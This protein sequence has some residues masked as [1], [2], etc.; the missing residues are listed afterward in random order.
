MSLTKRNDGITFR[1]RK[2]QLIFQVSVLHAVYR[3]LDNSSTLIGS[4][5]SYVIR[6]DSKC[7][8]NIVEV[9]SRYLASVLLPRLSE[10]VSVSIL[11][12]CEEV[13]AHLL[14]CLVGTIYAC[15]ICATHIVGSVVARQASFFLRSFTFR[16]FLVSNSLTGNLM[17]S[18]RSAYLFTIL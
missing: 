2:I 4:T 18:S 15:S 9:K 7:L 14:G 12:T 8:C 10:C 6:A 16:I 3:N 17:N 11:Q 5:Y 1:S 13:L